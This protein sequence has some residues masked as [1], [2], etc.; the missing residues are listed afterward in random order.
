MKSE[1]H[2]LV[3]GKP[4]SVTRQ[5]WLKWMKRHPLQT[6]IIGQTKIDKNRTVTT[7]FHGVAGWTKRDE[8]DVWQIG[9]YGTKIVCKQF[10][11]DLEDAKSWHEFTVRCFE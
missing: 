10:C 4:V 3:R 7:A 6:R 11:G 5:K 9:I 8:A 1:F 2:I